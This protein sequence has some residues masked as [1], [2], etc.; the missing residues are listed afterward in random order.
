MISE[1][2]AKKADVQMI[3]SERWYELLRG[4]DYVPID[5]HTPMWLWSRG[6]FSVKINEK[7]R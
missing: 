4:T 3:L 2:E 7:V 1:E 6:K 5:L